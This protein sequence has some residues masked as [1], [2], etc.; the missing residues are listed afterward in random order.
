MLIKI[1]WFIRALFLKLL[2]GSIGIPS[3]LG[4]PIYISGYKKIFLGCKVRIFPGLR[5]EAIGKNAKIIIKDNVSIGQNLH[6]TAMDEL[7]INQG[8][9]ITGNVFI[10]D[11]DHDYSEIG[12][13]IFSQKMLSKKTEIG[14][15]CFIGFGAGIQ[16]GT[17]L[18]EQCIVGAHSVV[19][20]VFPPFSVI[21]GAPAKV[22]KQY[23]PEKKKWFRTNIK[24]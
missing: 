19:R 4:K 2:L 11:I 6:I 17:I 24:K 9:L 7:V 5:I 16:A 21:S 15:N 23:D 14:K 8:T 12:Q 20:G 18:G 1:L 10:T 22:I 3:Y 13:P